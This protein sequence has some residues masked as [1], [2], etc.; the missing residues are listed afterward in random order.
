MTERRALITG[1]SGQDGAYLTELLLAKGYRVS[2]LDL[3]STKVL[4]L[5]GGEDPNPHIRLYEGS[6]ADAGF[7]RDAIVDAAPHELYHLAGRSHVGQSFE[8]PSEAVEI[9]AV[10]TMH[11]LDAIGAFDAGNRPRILL[12]SSCEVF[13]P[14]DGTPMNEQT[15]LDPQSPYGLSKE[16]AL[17]AGRQAR[18][19]YG[20]HLSNGIFFNHESPLR[21]PGFVTR[22]ISMGA[23]AIDAGLENELALGNL[24]ARRDWGHAAD[25]A[26]GMWRMLQQPQGDDYVLATGEAH[27]VR[28]FVERAFAQVGQVIEWHGQGVDEIGVD[29]GTGETLVRVDPR[30]FR[31]NE[32]PVRLGDAAKARETLGWTPR[33]SFADLVGEMTQNDCRI[34]AETNMALPR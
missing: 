19:L 24:D 10:G 13:G 27:S 16:L 15:P 2:G 20:L 3:P 21:G 6:V 14:G 9:N 4:R 17:K 23:A 26:G 31:P 12:A 28:E 18:E 11:V 33:V 8:T 1:I 7:V 5:P 29:P 30:F 32:V 22:K 34:A 25:F